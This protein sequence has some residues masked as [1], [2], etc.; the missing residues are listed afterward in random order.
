MCADAEEAAKRAWLAKQNIPSKPSAS[1]T[2]EEEAKAAWL[3]KQDVPS[4]R[5]A[6]GEGETWRAA[7]AR[8]AASALL[9]AAGGGV[10]P[11]VT[12]AALARG[13]PRT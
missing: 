13:R 2:S 4:P 12:P 3:A 1:G 7:P 5:A 11:A 10:L 6:P 9:G 8:A